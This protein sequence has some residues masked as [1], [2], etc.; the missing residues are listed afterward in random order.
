MEKETRGGFKVKKVVALVLILSIM[1]QGNTQVYAKQLQKDKA[2]TADRLAEICVENWDKYGVLPSVC[3]AQAFIESTLG[4]NCSGYNL[5]GIRSGA[6]NYSSLEEG[7]LRYLK[8]INNGYYYGAPFETDYRKQMKAIL[9]G[10]YCEPVGD[11]YENAIWSIETYKFY[12]YDK[13]IHKI[14]REREQKKVFTVIH[15]KSIPKG[16]V[17]IDKKIVRKGT[18][19][20]RELY[21][22]YDVVHG[23]KGRKIRLN[24]PKAD[25]LKVK[26]DVFENAVG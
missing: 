5:W 22:F 20:I 10:G 9:D 6:E 21:G 12:K 7:A 8:V 19:Q 17:A 3:V 26:L 13:K 18:V 1:W 14:I 23:G 2:N 4:E 16:K 15:D 25:G 11:Y 24:N